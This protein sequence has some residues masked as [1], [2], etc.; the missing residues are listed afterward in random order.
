MGRAIYRI[1]SPIIE[2]RPAIHTSVKSRLRSVAIIVHPRRG[3]RGRCWHQTEHP[4]GRF[5]LGLQIPPALPAG[6]DVLAHD[7]VTPPCGD[8]VARSAEQRE[9]RAPG[10]KARHRPTHRRWDRT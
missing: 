7:W 9:Y 6:P 5:H 2:I 3:A 10:A 8:T 1:Q 4:A